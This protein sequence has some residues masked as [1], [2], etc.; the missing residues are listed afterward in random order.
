MTTGILKK[1]FSSGNN[2]AYAHNN[3]GYVQSP[4][5]GSRDY[6]DNDYR[7][8]D[9][10]V[11]KNGYIRIGVVAF[12]LEYESGDC[13]YDYLEF[14]ELE[15]HDRVYVTFDNNA[16]AYHHFFKRFC[17]NSGNG[18]KRLH[19]STW[20]EEY[21]RI[22]GIKK[23]RVIFKTDGSTTRGGFKIEYQLNMGSFG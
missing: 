16:W 12:D 5:Y 18:D 8:A 23:L 1:T 15:K 7:T 6:S 13:N 20:T 17:G 11:V 19:G 10:S 21:Y 3:C 4:N 2:C 14:V 22:Y 9:I